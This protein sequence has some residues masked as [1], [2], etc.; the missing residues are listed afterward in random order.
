MSEALPPSIPESNDDSN[1]PTVI[2]VI[3]MAGS[4]K[5]TVMQRLNSQIRMEKKSPY[6]INLDPAVTHLP[7]SP[8]IDI[9][10]TVKYADV[11]SEYQLGPNG[12]ILTSL[13]LF[14]TRFDQVMGLLEQRKSSVDY[15]L[16]DT[17]G[18]IEVFT[19]SASGTIVTDALAATYPTMVLF[20]V[21]TPR[22][23]SP[24][25]FMS[26]MLYAC[27]ILYRTRLPFVVLFNKSDVIRSEFA[28]QWMQDFEKFQGKD[29]NSLF[30]QT[31]TL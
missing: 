17:P 28:I 24:A 10:D 21:D 15:I 14:T 31:A 29:M 2:L 30:L 22:T 23:A 12:A 9:R 5:T 13:N 26:N 3:G 1:L 11:M 8:N 6:I 7:Y 19:W 4:G 20:V 25:T 27:S 16:V 18:Q